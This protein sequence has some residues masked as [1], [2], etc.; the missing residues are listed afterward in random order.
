MNKQSLYK[1]LNRI[2]FMKLKDGFHYTG[3]ITKINE[4]SISFYDK[5]KLN[6]IINI[7][8]IIEIMEINET[9]RYGKQD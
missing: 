6:S 2:V 4:D 8:V 9:G 5:F 7:R 3:T 1:Y